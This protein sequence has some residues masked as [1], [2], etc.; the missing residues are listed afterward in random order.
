MSKD[1]ELKSRLADIAVRYL[2]RTATEIEQLRTLIASVTAGDK[3]VLRDIEVL[4]H[5]IRGSG[6]VFGFTEISAAAEALETV[7]VEQIRSPRIDFARTT[8][9]LTA[10][11][12]SLASAVAAASRSSS[13]NSGSKSS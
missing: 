7:A 6:A 12:D 10:L 1:E 2:V 3:P 4:V 5:R 11:T 13:E 8:E 9:Q